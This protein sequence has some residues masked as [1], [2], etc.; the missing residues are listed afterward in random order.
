MTAWRH[1]GLLLIAHGSERGDGAVLTLQRHRDA[2]RA[3]GLF[4][5]VEIAFLRGEPAPGKALAAMAPKLV[6]VVPHFMSDGFLVR[7]AVPQAL[8][9]SGGV[10]HEGAAGTHTVRYCRSTGSHRHLPDLVERRLLEVSSAHGFAPK[11][12]AALIIGHGT[13]RDPASAAHARR[14]AHALAARGTFREVAIGLLEEPPHVVEALQQLGGQQIAVIGLFAAEGGHAAG[15]VP[16]LIAA[17]RRDSDWMP[18]IVYAGAVG[19]DPAIPSFVTDLVADFD[20]EHADTTARH[21]PFGD[22][23]PGTGA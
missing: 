16:D 12:T 11:M 18:S 10:S 5:Q 9:I 1:S 21:A 4:G 6:Y 15:D 17:A 20:A 23:S 2:L 14:M 19:A 7:E 3:T 22:T 8:G 13:P